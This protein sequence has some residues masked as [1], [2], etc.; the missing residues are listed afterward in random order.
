[1][2]SS[3]IRKKEKAKDYSLQE[4]RVTLTQCQAT[5]RGD[6]ADHEVY[7]E[8]GKWS[9]DCYYF[10]SRETCTHTMAMALMLRDMVREKAGEA[11]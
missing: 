5:F 3:L 10:V 4:E 8:G 6:N 11:V 1:M 7:Y 9:C 2:D